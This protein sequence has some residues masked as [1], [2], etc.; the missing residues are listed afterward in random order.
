[1]GEVIPLFGNEVMTPERRRELRIRIS[2]LA[3]HISLMESE[4]Q[5]LERLLQVPDTTDPVA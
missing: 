4:K 2:E 5:R 1:M 3:L